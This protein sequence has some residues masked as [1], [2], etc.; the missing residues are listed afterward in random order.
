MPLLSANQRTTKPLFSLI[1]SRDWYS[2]ACEHNIWRVAPFTFA[3]Q[4]KELLHITMTV[5]S[6]KI[7]LKIIYEK[8]SKPLFLAGDIPAWLA[9]NMRYGVQHQERQTFG[10]AVPNILGGSRHMLKQVD[11]PH[12]YTG[13]YEHGFRCVYKSSTITFHSSQPFSGHL[14]F[15]YN[16]KRLEPSDTP[17]EVCPENSLSFTSDYW[18]LL[19]LE[20]TEDDVI[21]ATLMQVGWFLLHSTTSLILIY[22]TARWNVSSWKC[23]F[24]I[25]WDGFSNMCDSLFRITVRAI[26][27]NVLASGILTDIC[28]DY[29]YQ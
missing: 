8:T 23:L 7:I 21:D 1:R 29:C 26:S 17:L 16:E 3:C 15:Y 11:Y 18:W 13:A 10:Q 19:Q 9:F 14:R 28:Q 5:E 4:F 22:L 25:G 24:I 27:L 20:M 12:S 6:E 2:S